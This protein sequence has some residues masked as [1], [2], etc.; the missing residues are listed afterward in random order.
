MKVELGPLRADYVAPSFGR[1][2]RMPVDPRLQQRLRRPMI[3]GGTIIGVFVL[4]LGLWASL[5]PLASGVT[6]PG[7]VT[8]E[9]N[10]KNI[11]HKEVG[12]VRQIL[13]KEGELVHANQPLIIFDDTEAKASYDVYQ[14][15]VDSLLAQTARLTAET[16][17][18]PGIQFP[19]E[20]T[21]RMKDPRVAALIRDQQFLFTSKLQ[22]FQ[23]QSSVLGQRLDQ[24]QNQIQ[25]D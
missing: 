22:L 13:V 5:A 21:G 15:Q 18:R 14:N 17:N 1:D 4:G 7:E 11:R 10:R 8:V 16:T 23:S 19:A 2:E 9:A 25:G 20:L 24:I 3:I 12:V 6:A